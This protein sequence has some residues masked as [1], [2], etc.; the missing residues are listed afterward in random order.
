M[1]IEE[2]KL[3]VAEIVAEQEKCVKEINDIAKKIDKKTQNAAI[4]A[5]LRIV[6]IGLHIRSLESQK[7]VILA[8]PLNN[9]ANITRHP[10]KQVPG[11]RVSE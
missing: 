7:Q 2:R 6:D 1:T 10:H 11:L 9:G 3:L 5:A 4:I 8:A